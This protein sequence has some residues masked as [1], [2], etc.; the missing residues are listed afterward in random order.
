M[1]ENAKYIVQIRYLINFFFSYNLFRI[2]N[3]KSTYKKNLK[4]L[5]YPTNQQSTNFLGSK[6]L[7]ELRQNKNEIPILL[8]LLII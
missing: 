2:L 3:R 1:Q 8:I 6:V 7:R 5:E 4:T